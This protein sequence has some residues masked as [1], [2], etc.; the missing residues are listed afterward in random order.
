MSMSLHKTLLLCLTAFVLAVFS[1]TQG[2]TPDPLD[3]YNVVWDRPSNDAKDSMPI[4]NGDIGL[5]VWAE[6]NGDLLFYIS[7]TDS[8]SENGRLLKLG[9]VRVKLSPNPFVKGSPFQQ[10]LKLRQGEIVITAG[11]KDSEIMTRIWVDAHHPVIRVETE[12]KEQFEVQVSLETW[13][14]KEYE[15]KVTTTSD[16]YNVIQEDETNF[17]AKGNLYPTVVFPDV[18]VPGKKDRVVWYHHNIKSGWPVTMK[19]QGLQ[20]LMGSMTDPLL[21]RTFGGSLQGTGFM[22][23][24]GHTLKSTQLRKQHAVSIYVLTKHPATVAQWQ[25]QL[26]ETIAR[27]EKIRIKTAHQAH[28]TWW[29][30]FWNRSW[31]RISRSEDGEVA[32]KGYTLFRYKH[33]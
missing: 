15:L 23:V 27:T 19:L 31:I 8:W 11:R 14:Q 26:D 20:S 32:S 29:N 21:G 4:G 33:S 7:K 30:N 3:R 25:K 24:N 16:I 6:E 28:Y 12:G 1:T 5:N 13:R 10:T 22:K 2:Q 9:R 18:I 17:T